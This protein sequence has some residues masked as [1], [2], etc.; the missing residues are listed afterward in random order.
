MGLFA[1]AGSGSDDARNA[2]FAMRNSATCR[3]ELIET[4]ESAGL[5]C[6]WA[7]D[8]EGKITYLSDTAVATLGLDGEESPVAQTY[9]IGNAGSPEDAG[10]GHEVEAE[11]EAIEYGLDVFLD[12]VLQWAA[13][14]VESLPAAHWPSPP[15]AARAT[16]ARAD[17][18]I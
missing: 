8:A 6:F 13:V 17:A 9:E 10:V 1:R 11:G 14:L 12:P 4:Y 18:G 15:S 3:L 2:P 16:A 7:T 5:G